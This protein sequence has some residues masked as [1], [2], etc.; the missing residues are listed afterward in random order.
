M[1]KTILISVFLLFISGNIFSQ[2]KTKLIFDYHPDTMGIGPL[3]RD[4]AHDHYGRNESLFWVKWAAVKDIEERKAKLIEYTMES[5]KEAIKYYEELMINTSSVTIYVYYSIE[6]YNY[7]NNLENYNKHDSNSSTTTI[8]KV[9]DLF[10]AA[11]IF[12]W[13]DMEKAANRLGFS[14]D[15]YLYY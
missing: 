8:D 12:N 3:S 10:T 1:K 2:Q 13:D 9:E 7:Y 15:K 4:V 14:Y 5:T 11:L 6:E